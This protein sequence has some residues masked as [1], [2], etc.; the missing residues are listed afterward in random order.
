[1]ANRETHV[2]NP[3]WPGLVGL[4]GR[5]VADVVAGVR[6][7]SG[8][9]GGRPM[10]TRPKDK[11]GF[12]MPTKPELNEHGGQEGR[13]G[14]AAAIEELLNQGETPAWAVDVLEQINAPHVSTL[15]LHLLRATVQLVRIIETQTGTDDIRVWV[16]DDEQLPD[17]ARHALLRFLGTA[18]GFERDR[19]VAECV[20]VE[21]IITNYL[22]FTA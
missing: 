17:W 21:R 20:M 15:D 11:K 7:R 10:R 1:M 16:E 5:R 22:G 3:A 9:R 2:L 8:E 4:C 6:E 18:R 19:Q 14:R 12:A 13:S